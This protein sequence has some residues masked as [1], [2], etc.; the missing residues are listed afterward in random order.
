MGARQGFSICLSVPDVISYY[1]N[2]QVLSGS[3]WV[4]DLSLPDQVPAGLVSAIYGQPEGGAP[5]TQARIEPGSTC[6]ETLYV[7]EASRR[8]SYRIGL[9]M[10]NGMSSRTEPITVVADDQIAMRAVCGDCSD[11]TVV[12]G[13]TAKF[14]VHA[15]Y[16]GHTQSP[17]QPLSVDIQCSNPSA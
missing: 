3:A 1:Y 6:T 12:Q 14:G 15:M 13:F 16:R 2:R 7:S 11:L 10:A 4:M 5:V 17:S 8:G 9:S